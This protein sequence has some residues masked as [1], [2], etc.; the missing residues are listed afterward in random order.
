MKVVDEPTLPRNFLNGKPDP[1]DNPVFPE[2]LDASM[3]EELPVLQARRNIR[4]GPAPCLSYI[5]RIDNA[6]H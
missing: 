5:K 2:P 1:A 6:K 3:D 4:L